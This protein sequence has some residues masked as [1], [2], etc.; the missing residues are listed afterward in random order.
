MND[1][2]NPLRGLQQAASGLDPTTFVLALLASLLSALLAGALYRLFYERQGTGSQVH[3]AF[4]LLGIS[5]TSLFVSI[6]TSLPLSL[7]LLGALSI[8]RF[9]TPIKE[10]EEV[11]FIML[12]IASSVA[13]ATLNFEFLVLL[14]ALA[15][16]T[17]VV[18]HR[19]RGWR[20]WGRDGVIVLQGSGAETTD[21]LQDVVRFIQEHTRR[22]SLD[23]STFRDGTTSLQF[24]FTGLK[25]SLPVFQEGLRTRGRFDG[26]NI[27]FNRPGGV[28]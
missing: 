8:I 28:G 1:P 3:R 4:P 20:Q 12:V 22:S 16:L 21:S 26:I 9:R 13:C 23:S 19:V 27:F 5:I 6:Q 24:S 7:G 14:N 11:G 25:A 17:L 10:P 2:L 18:V 15:V